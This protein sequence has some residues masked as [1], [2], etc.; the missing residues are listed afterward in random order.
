MSTVDQI[1]DVETLWF[2][3]KKP[4]ALPIYECFAE[5]LYER[6]PD[7]KRRVQKTQITFSN[8]YVFACIS[9]QRV[10]RKRNFQIRIWWLHSGCLFR[11]SRIGLQLN[12]SHT[13]A[14]GRHIL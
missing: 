3:E 5:R 14:G 2:F 4:A 9:F 6:F 1:I 13:Q 12:Q 7:T 8:R 11:W 10:K